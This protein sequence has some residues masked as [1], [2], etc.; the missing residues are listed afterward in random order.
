MPCI[1]SCVPEC[2]AGCL[3][4]NNGRWQSRWYTRGGLDRWDSEIIQYAI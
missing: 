3:Y 1:H 4:E 2:V